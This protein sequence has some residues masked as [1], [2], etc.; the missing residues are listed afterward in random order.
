MSQT[1][2]LAVAA[3]LVAPDQVTDGHVL[4]ALLLEAIQRERMWL[5]DYAWFGKTAGSRRLCE[6]RLKQWDRFM[7]KLTKEE[8]GLPPAPEAS[9]YAILDDGDIQVGDTITEAKGRRHSLD[10]PSRLETLQQIVDA[11]KRHLGE[12]A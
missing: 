9:D 8:F 7:A 10:F 6:R 2:F 11:C 1:H 3:Q 12:Q 5:Q 4:A